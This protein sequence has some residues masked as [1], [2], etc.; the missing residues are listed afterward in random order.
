[1]N[2]YL[3]ERLRHKDTSFQGLGEREDGFPNHTQ[4]G[5]MMDHSTKL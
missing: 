2:K 3:R 4:G 5:D 1:M